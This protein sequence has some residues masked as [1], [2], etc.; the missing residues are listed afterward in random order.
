[1]ECRSACFTTT[2]HYESPAHGGWGVI[3]LHPLF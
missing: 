2:L 1:M 3:P